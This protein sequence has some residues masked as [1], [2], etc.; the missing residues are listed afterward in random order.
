MYTQMY[1]QHVQQGVNK[2][3]IMQKFLVNNDQAAITVAVEDLQ[4]W[5]NGAVR[6]IRDLIREVRV[7]VIRYTG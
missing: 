7:G 3:L 6:G 5:S 1:T 4:S 2:L